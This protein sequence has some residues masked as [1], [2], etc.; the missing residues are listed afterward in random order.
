MNMNE[1]SKFTEDDHC[2]CGISSGKSFPWHN[3]PTRL[4]PL[5]G[6]QQEEADLCVLLGRPEVRL[7]TL[8]G[9]AGVGKTS[10]GV[11]VARDLPGSFADGVFF[12]SLASVRDADLVL[13]TLVQ[14]LGL[15]TVGNQ[16]LFHQLKVYLQDKH[17][18]LFLDN[19]EQV[20]NA[21]WLLTDLL[22]VCPTLRILVT[23]REVL[24]LRV[25]H[26][27]CVLPLMLPGRIG[28]LDEKALAH[29]AAVELFLQRAQ[30]IKP[31]FQLTES[32][33]AP[34]AEICIR[35]D[36]LPLAIELAAARIKLLSPQALLVR[37]SQR[38]QVLTRG[39]REAP[40][41][42]QT[43][44]NTLDWSY[45]LLN[46]TEQRLFRRI[47]VF[48][49]GCTLDAI[50]AVCTALGD[51]AEQVLDGVAALID[52]SLLQRRG[53]EECCILMLETIREYA[54]ETLAASEEAEA[55][56]Q[57]HAMYYLQLGE[58][59]APKLFGAEGKKWLASL[60]QEQENLRVALYW[61]FERNERELALRLCV[62]LSSFLVV[63]G[64]WSEGRMLLEK[65]LPALQDSTTGLDTILEECF[66]HLGESEITE[67]GWKAVV[68][69]LVAVVALGLDDVGKAR[70][71]IEENLSVFRTK[72]YRED[73]A[74][75]FVILEHLATVWAQGRTM[76]PEQVLSEQGR[77]RPTA[78][79][80]ASQT[81]LDAIPAGLTPREVEVL[82]LLAQGLT[83]AQI[84]EQLVVSP[85]TVDAHL[86]TIY[87]K[88][89]VKSRSAATRYALEQKLA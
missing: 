47:S 45:H 52:K 5:V 25:E 60:E 83:N 39:T 43:L 70:I 61:L 15:K 22:E 32:N 67:D 30:A 34:I 65:A 29:V 63:R 87:S 4:T 44:R 40:I 14:A 57:A 2:V 36:G 84:A 62:A 41:R 69:N 24:R 10:L 3:L 38:L 74:D 9:P 71:L 20:V 73:F 82:R 50:E 33:A 21:A 18:L 35:L 77:P 28:H 86:T 1:D 27:F 7:L 56:R 12:V 16:S 51:D 68:S 19:F 72:G 46:V 11:Q 55:C 85:R 23:S 26:Q 75:S 37:L 58:E 6:R 54:L 13:S 53:H 78:V 88:I 59:A 81:K 89:G 17:S 76:T 42:Q 48:V 8:T 80:S 79:S 49:G 31:D 66:V 64:Y